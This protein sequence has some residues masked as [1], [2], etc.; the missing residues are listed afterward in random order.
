MDDVGKDFLKSFKRRYPYA[1]LKCLRDLASSIKEG[2]Y[3]RL[4]PEKSDALY[5]VA[6]T[7]AKIPFKD[8]FKARAT[9]PTCF[10]IVSRR[11]ARFTRRGRVLIALEKDGGFYADV[12]LEWPLLYKIIRLNHELVYEYFTLNK[13]CPAFINRGNMPKVLKA[14]TMKAGGKGNID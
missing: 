14:I 10:V 13:N 11:A 8:G 2:K 5:V 6:L 9:T 12:V 7:R 4:H 1:S 3:W